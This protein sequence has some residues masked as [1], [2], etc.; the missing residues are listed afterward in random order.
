[1]SEPQHPAPWN[2]DILDYIGD[3]LDNEAYRQGK[4][5]LHVLDP[6]GGIGLIHELPHNTVTVEIEPEWADQGAELGESWVGDSTDLHWFRTNSFDAWVTSVTFG[7][8]MGDHHNNKDT[9]KKCKGKGW[10]G[11][12]REQCSVCKGV[13][14][15]H[16]RTYK[17]YLGHDLKPNN[18]GGE[19]WGKRYRSL[20]R[21]FVTEG[22]RV[23]RSGGLA[24]LNI[25]NH[26]RTLR[27]GEDPVEQRVS[28]WWMRELIRQG[29]TIDHVA[30]INTRK[31]KFGANRH[32]TDGELVIVTRVP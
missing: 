30:R 21:A 28:E 23:V 10:F 15:S 27:T 6:F 32:R 4:K 2:M 7:N 5:K 20:H 18:T 26:Y 31:Y 19:Q 16:R 25:T 9:C 17:H 13:G 14:L 22:N 29:H 24:I 1:M 8:R 3:V 12:G 11:R